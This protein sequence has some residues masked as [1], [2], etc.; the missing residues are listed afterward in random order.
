MKVK[1]VQTLQFG[2]SD[3][4]EVVCDRSMVARPKTRWGYRMIEERRV[5]IFDNGTLWQMRRI[6][7]NWL[8]R[9]RLR[10]EQ[11][12]RWLNV[13]A[14]LGTHKHMNCN[15]WMSIK[16][17]EFGPWCATLV[18]TQMAL[19]HSHIWAI[20]STPGLSLATN[21]GLIKFTDD[22]SSCIYMYAYTYTWYLKG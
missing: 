14:S 15:N 6:A 5:R 12:I 13:D 3:W 21:P 11:T 7:T 10:L 19:T 4:N 22:A 8:R 9:C 18:C 17:E 20:S 2:K 16:Y 1:V